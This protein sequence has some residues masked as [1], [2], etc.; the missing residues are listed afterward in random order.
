MPPYKQL[1]LDRA[2]NAAFGNS[3]TPQRDITP[4]AAAKR[5]RE[6]S[7]THYRDKAS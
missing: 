2:G 3:Q 4:E 1:Q 5:L 6:L 7:A